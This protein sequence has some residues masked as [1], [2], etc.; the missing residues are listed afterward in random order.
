MKKKEEEEVIAISKGLREKVVLLAIG[1]VVTIL[2]FLIS[3]YTSNFVTYA[4]YNEDKAIWSAILV[5]QKNMK[6]DIKEIKD[7]TKKQK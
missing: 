5:N 7:N 6:D 2:T 1:T 4:V 3:S